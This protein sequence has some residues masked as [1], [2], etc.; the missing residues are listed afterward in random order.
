MDVRLSPEQVAFHD[1]ATPVVDRLGVHRVSDLDDRA[2]ATKLDAAVCSS[3]WREL[4][5][6]TDTGTPWASA[7][8]VAVVAEELGRGLAD[9]AFLGPTMAAELRRLTGAPPATEPET[10]ALTSDLVQPAT[11]ESGRVP[12]GAVA[13][14]AHGASAALVLVGVANGYTIGAATLEG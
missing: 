13:I 10:V 12:P 3:G 4:R 1:A 5:T 2:R 14:D 8:E 11:D 6:P 9:V 7:V